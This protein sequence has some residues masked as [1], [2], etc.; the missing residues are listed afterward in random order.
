MMYWIALQMIEQMD[1]KGGLFEINK[2]LEK[3]V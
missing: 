2:E 1:Y 3:K